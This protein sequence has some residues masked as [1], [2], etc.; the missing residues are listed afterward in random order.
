MH[1]QFA[2]LP[3]LDQDRAKKF[4]IERFACTLV[5]DAPLGSP[6]GW[7]WIELALDGAET[8]LHFHRRG[9]E[10]PS[11]EPDMLFVTAD[12]VREVER[13][14]ALGVEILTEPRPA[15][16]DPRRTTAEFRDSEGNRMVLASPLT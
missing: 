9:S 5:A 6:D 14:R 15:P 1:V 8:H 3:V 7:R 12:V 13:L 2:E 4:Y 11:V 16:W 10:A